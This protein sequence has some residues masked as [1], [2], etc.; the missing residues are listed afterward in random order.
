MF[1]NFEIV[2]PI[3]SKRVLTRPIDRIAYASDASFY[4]LIPQ[5]VVQPNSIAE[6]QALFQFSHEQSVPLVFRAAGTSLS[7][8]SITDGIL[9]D[10]SKHW[11]GRWVEKDGE[12][13]RLQPSV[14]GAHA[15]VTLQP[16]SRRIGPDPASIDSCM[17]GGILANNASGMCC[18][19]AENAYHTLHSM[20]IL[21]PNGLVVDT[22]AKDAAEKLMHSSPDVV[23]GLLDLRRR[24]F[25]NRSLADRITQRY[26]RKNTTGY[27]LNALTDFSEPIDILSH[28]L[29]GSE[30][31]LGFIAEA[32]LH[33]LPT[34][35]FKFT[36]LLFF[37]TVQQAA[38]S[39]P[40]LVAS[41][42]RALEIMDRAALRSI[43]NF[44]GALGEIAQLPNQAAALL[45][46]YQASTSDEM[47]SFRNAALLTCA[48]L[49]TLVPTTFTEDPIQQANL[50]KLRKGMFPAIGATRQPGTT[51]IIEDVA[52]A[53]SQIADAITDLQNLFETHGYTEGII[54]GHAKDG[55]LHFVIT[56][57]FNEESEIQRYERFM[58]ELVRMVTE[59]YDGALK[60]E[61]GTGRNMA[62]FVEQ[63]WGEEAYQIM[64]EI[65]SLLDPSGLLNPGVIINPDSRAHLQNLKN[66]PE[67]TSSVD[68][69]IECGFCEVKCPSRRLT[70]TPRQ[71]IVLQREIARRKQVSD[72]HLLESLQN[73]FQYSGL[74]TCAVDGLCATACPVLINTGT[75]VKDLRRQQIP[76]GNQQIA[77]YIFRHFKLAE[78]TLRVGLAVGHLLDKLIGTD[79]IVALTQ[80]AEKI[81]GKHLPKWNEA[82]PGPT[83]HIPPTPHDHADYVYF[84]SC[85]ARVMGRPAD[86]KN[87]PSLT[88]TFLTVSQRAGVSV[89]IPDDVE[90]HCCGMPF[91][92][93]GYKPANQAML[94]RTISGLWKWSE[95]G[96]LPVVLDASSCAYSLRTSGAELS[97][98]DHDY[99]QRIT[100]LDPIEFVHD[101]LLP[102]LKVQHLPMSVVL[103][104]NCSSRHLNLQEK[105]LAIAR[106]CAISATIPN[107]LD[108]CGFAGDRG[109][110]FP[111]LTASASL[112]EASEISTGQYDGYYSSNPTCEMG[113]TIATKKPYRSFLY[114]LEMATREM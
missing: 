70:L 41:G 83:W 15:N 79:G 48:H 95:R 58:A 108:C 62:P 111:E 18:G 60:A 82:V 92:S 84:P 26:Q 46:E 39:I 43:Q 1:P 88:D 51:V 87:S 28:L 44:P 2:P 21:L 47:N 31:T 23:K 100:I 112:F 80:A 68:R 30:G 27:S 52:F 50:W 86:G 25:S 110:L 11:G 42:A 71:R 73:D 45:V 20:T 90:G 81:S 78:Q 10:L 75:L 33:T 97:P 22:D 49:K 106:C 103:H 107:N 9:I 91:G 13:I 109:L 64:Q 40:L 61:H 99:W 6:V 55:N 53:I 101:I 66:L 16:Y 72:S 34:Y 24:V 67:I 113:M 114:L 63:E 29:I 54:F 12:L 93:K 77:L 59:K 89:W 3:D 76:E 102:R 37:D 35:R 57:S 14:I 69:C 105:L 36:S 19:V 96:R 98:Q 17:I 32:V 4:R 5:A 74:D 85:I 38:S 8:Q 104:P 56:Q 7:G 65:K 94:H